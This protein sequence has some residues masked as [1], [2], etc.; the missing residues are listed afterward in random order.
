[1]SPTQ[2][3]LYIHVI[4]TFMFYCFQLSFISHGLKNPDVFCFADY[5][6]HTVV[7]DILKTPPDDDN[8]DIVTWYVTQ[9][10]NHPKI[11]QTKSMRWFVHQ[12]LQDIKI[13][14]IGVVKCALFNILYTYMRNGAVLKNHMTGAGVTR[15]ISMVN[16]SGDDKK[17]Y[18]RWLGLATTSPII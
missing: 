8:R 18:W 12:V 11:D 2:F 14:L 7:I 13:L 6:C 9:Y 5:P 4:L 10:I 3:L 15:N 17:K 16:I 1:M